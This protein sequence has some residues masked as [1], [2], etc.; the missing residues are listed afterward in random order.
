M[1]LL[2][3]IGGVS[4]SGKT[5]VSEFLVKTLTHN[6]KRF[7][8]DDFF[9]RYGDY[10][11]Q[12]ELLPEAH[13]QCQMNVEECMSEETDII[14]VDNTFTQSWELK[15]YLK[16]AERFEYETMYL[17]TV[18]HHGSKSIHNVPSHSVKLQA[19]KLSDTL[20]ELSLKPY[21]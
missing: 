1:K 12:P 4:G 21:I 9:I 19:E 17:L 2:M 16:L 14:I 5:G 13:K 3:L 7:S 8:A 11:F 18:N 15:P 20:V 6:A 10:H